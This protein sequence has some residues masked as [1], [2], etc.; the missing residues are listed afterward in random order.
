MLFDEDINGHGLREKIGFGWKRSHVYLIG[1]EDCGEDNG[2]SRGDNVVLSVF[3]PMLG[4]D[5]KRERLVKGGG[6]CCSFLGVFLGFFFL[7]F[8]LF[9]TSLDFEYTIRYCESTNLE[10]K[11]IKLKIIKLLILMSISQLVRF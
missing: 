1:E 7:D 6:S 4:L 5:R 3:D 2:S 10:L 11:M 8:L 9:L